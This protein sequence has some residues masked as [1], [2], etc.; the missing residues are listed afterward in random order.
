MSC[1]SEPPANSIPLYRIGHEV[2]TERTGPKAEP[3]QDMLV[4]R[5]IHKP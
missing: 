4:C 5:S 1:R 2:V 3:I